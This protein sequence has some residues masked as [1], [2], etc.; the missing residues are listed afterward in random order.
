VLSGAP[1]HGRHS[2]DP[3][4]YDLYRRGRHYW[5]QDTPDEI[6]H[7]LDYFRRALD[8][9]PTY[10]AAYAGLADS[11]ARLDDM[12][13]VSQ[14][15]A[16][17]RAA[18]AARRALA[19][20]STVAEAHAALGHI[21]T[22]QWRWADAERE[23]RLAL[24]LD[25]S[26]ANARLWYSTYLMATGRAQEA[27]EEAW[28]ARALDPLSVNVNWMA[29][30]NLGN[31]GR[32][33]EALA[34][35]TSA[36]DLA[37]GHRGILYRIAVQHVEMGRYAEGIAELE[38]LGARG[39]VARA[40]ALSGESAA[41]RAIL[42]DLENEGLEAGAPPTEHERRRWEMALAYL[43]LGDHDRALYWLEQE[44][45]TGSNMSL[46]VAS[47]RRLDPLRS[48]P[49]FTPLLQRLGLVP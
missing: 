30:A 15:E 16:R 3:A 23:L 4:A 33:E 7:G 35:F 36:L 26:S 38:R 29:G 32:H 2:P 6:R 39:Y 11:Y 17:P 31:L 14:A 25:P 42:R 22:H 21:L 1:D 48:D 27:V 5:S 8:V 20:D 45:A 40:R 49:R 43:A 37:P 19:L 46:A 44:I 18:A 47:S 13:A 9:D 12:S 24:A 41:A 28:R 10:A 34:A